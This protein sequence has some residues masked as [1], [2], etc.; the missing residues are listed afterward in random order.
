MR[1]ERRWLAIFAAA[2]I[3][4]LVGLALARGAPGASAQVGATPTP[5]AG[6]QTP[7][8]PATPAASPTEMAALGPASGLGWDVEAVATPGGELPTPV[9]VDV[10]LVVDGLTDPINVVASPDDTARLF[11]VERNGVVRIVQDG[12]LL[13]EPF[14]DL[15]PMVLD[16]FLEQGFYDIEFHPDYDTNGR[17]FV[18]FA[19]L[20][21]NGDSV[22]V[23]YSVSEDDPDVADPD[24]AR[25]ILVIEQPYANHNGG[26]L[27]FGPDGYLYIGS[28]DGG[29]EGDPLEAGQDLSTLLGKLLRID[30]DA[31]GQGRTYGIPED[32]PYAGPPPLVQLF[33]IDEDVFAAI[34]TRA[35]PEIWHYGL[36]NPWKFSFDP[37]TG[38]LWMPDVGQNVWEE[39]NYVPADT[40]G[41]LNFGW[42]YLMGT[43]CHPIQAESCPLVGVLPAAEYDHDLGCAVIG[44]GVYRGQ[45]IPELDGVYLAGDFCSGRIWGVT[46]AD[47]GE[48]AMA[49]LIQT[50]LR[51]TGGG[52]D[53]DG[54]LYVTSCECDYGSG[55]PEENPPGALWRVVPA[56]EAPGMSTATPGAAGTPTGTPMTPA[57]PGATATPPSA[58]TPQAMDEDDLLAMGEEL[59]VSNCAGCHQEGGQ[60]IPGAFPALDRNPTVT[61]D[62]PHDAIE[63][64]IEGG[65]GMPA[66]GGILS[67]EEI[68]AVVSYIRN[69]WTNEAST[70]TVEQVEEVRGDD[71]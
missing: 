21:R 40:P 10:E 36:R 39:I 11:V 33:G 60:G 41:G 62:D 22:I 29:W 59:F 9:E 14:L 24:S 55:T 34:H 64:V 20:L 50:D 70:V 56:G 27:A 46:R 38:D 43:H 65:G 49:E 25:I 67:D 44:L 7:T 2:L 66:Y 31:E 17:F 28:G 12:E 13:D 57:A 54:E 18:H 51:I 8:G 63:Q 71:S 15:S 30:V 5:A 42:D 16:A 32:N 3:V 45:E 35:R 23:E 58:A 68:A 61:D 48:F 53:R 47:D 37:E 1:S 69:A 4:G 26:E 19:E 52:I 6:A